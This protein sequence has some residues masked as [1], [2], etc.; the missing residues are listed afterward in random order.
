MENKAI[1]NKG[2]TLNDGIIYWKDIEGTIILLHSEEKEVY[3]LN[4]VA[5][6]ICRRIIRKEP[7]EK[8]ISV[9]RKE[10]KEIER[11]TIEKDTFSFIKKGLKKNFF[12][13]SK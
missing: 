6:F 9:L 10:Y 13:V 1:L 11:Q 2:I 12:L 4:E 7:I 8:I 3:E 5:S